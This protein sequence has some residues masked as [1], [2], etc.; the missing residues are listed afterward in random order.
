MLIRH[1]AETCALMQH[2]WALSNCASIGI[3]ENYTYKIFRIA[4]VK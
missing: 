2:S 4:D 1:K 3:S